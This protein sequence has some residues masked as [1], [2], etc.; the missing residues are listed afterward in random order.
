MA[1]QSVK[2]TINNQ[3]VTLSYNAENEAWE[4]TTTAPSQSS[5]NQD[6]HYYG[7]T[8][9]AEDDSGNK[10]T[11]SDTVGEFTESLKLVVKEKNAPEITAI[12][13]TQDAYLTN[14]SPEIQWSITD[15]DSGVDESTITIT[16]DGTPITEGITKTADG[17]GYT[18]SYTPASALA[19][20]VHTIQ[21]DAS[22]HDGNAAT[23]QV[24]SFTVD[25]VAPSLDLTSPE[26]ELGT[27]AS[28]IIVSGTTN[29]AT[30]GPVTVTVNGDPVTVSES[31]TF[32][33]EVTLV[34]GSNTITVI[35]TDK[36]GKSTTITRIVYLDTGAPV[37][38]SIELIPNPVDAGQTYIIRVKVTDD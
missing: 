23:Q 18:C 24:V 4:A 27:N 26:D 32:S 10:T 19:D 15:D 30:S 25:T 34:E 17:K 16:I 8:I 13:P 6:G 2:A 38:Q 14:D 21:F 1:V 5:Y 9:V 36:A 7:V 3:E 20:G 28:T 37:F 29:D 33:K 31:G 12:S 35:A 22:D 11:V